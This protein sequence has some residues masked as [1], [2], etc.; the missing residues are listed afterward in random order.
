MYITSE[1]NLHVCNQKT[2]VD[3]ADIG[4]TNRSTHNVPSSKQLAELVIDSVLANWEKSTYHFCSRII[5]HQFSN[6]WETNQSINRMVSVRRNKPT[7]KK[8]E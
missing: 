6:N 5:K 2:L 8:A 4:Y 1:D 7:K 3:L